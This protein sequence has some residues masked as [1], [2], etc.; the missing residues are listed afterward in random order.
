ME[1]SDIIVYEGITHLSVLYDLALLVLIYYICI[2]VPPGEVLI[3]K[4]A[5][6]RCAT[7]EGTDAGGWEC[8]HAET[9]KAAM[10]HADEQVGRW[11]G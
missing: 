11:G 6:L 5:C 3:V 9:L 8:L 7:M 4:L 10:H 2:L 1:Q